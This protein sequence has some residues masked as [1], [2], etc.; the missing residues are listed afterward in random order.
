MCLHTCVYMFFCDVDADTCSPD[1]RLL[2]PAPASNALDLQNKT[3]A[4]MDNAN[5]SDGRTPHANSCCLVP[6]TPL[7][8]QSLPL[9]AS[10][11]I[12]P[13]LSQRLLLP[14]PPWLWLHS[15]SLNWLELVLG[16]APWLELHLGIGVCLGSNLSSAAC[17]GQ[18][19]P[20][21]RQSCR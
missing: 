8:S 17:C 4:A 5:C 9:P 18:A 2:L 16:V 12:I 7:L 14:A 1:R 10:A 20:Q 21:A 13:L 19:R 3:I 6:P 15:M 11:S